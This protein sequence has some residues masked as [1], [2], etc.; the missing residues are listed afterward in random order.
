MTLYYRY[1]RAIFESLDLFYSTF[2]LLFY[3]KKFST[4]CSFSRN[5]VC[6]FNNNKLNAQNLNLET[7]LTT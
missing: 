2:L 4:Y 1:I 6:I 7:S 5:T 3:S